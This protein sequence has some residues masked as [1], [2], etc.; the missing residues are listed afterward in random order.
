MNKKILDYIDKCE[1]WKT[2]IKQLHWNADN[3][4]QHQLCDDIAD[5]ISDFQDQVS[6]VEQSIDGNLKFNKLKPTEY[7]VKNLR[8]FVQDVLDDTN[9]FYKSLPNDDNHTGMKSDCESFLSDMQRKLYLVNFTMKEDLRRRIRNSIN[10]SRPK[11]LANVSDVEKFKGRRPKSIKA[12]I[13]KI[14]RIIKK[15]G[16]DSRTYSDDH[17]QALSDYKR[18]ITSLGCEFNCWCEDGGYTDRDPSD[19]MPRAKEYKVMIT[20]DDGMVI[21]GYIKM[22]ASGTV[23]DPFSSYD[24]CIV[25]WSKEQSKIK[26]EKIL[27]VTNEDI[28]R[29]VCESLRSIIGRS[30]K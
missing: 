18:A 21:G 14:Y 26:E 29:L 5:R 3:M 13:N 27:E 24:S 20:F 30:L 11:N 2:A 8:T 25:L 15:Y 7:K 22:M 9:M 19:G 4:S 6:E 16:I 10:E 17:W 12:R 28:Q 23:K 1:G